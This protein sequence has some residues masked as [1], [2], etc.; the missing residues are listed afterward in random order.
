MHGIKIT[1]ENNERAGGT[2]R[3]LPSP[4]SCRR[5]G[6][7]VVVDSRAGGAAVPGRGLLLVPG[8]L[9][10]MMLKLKRSES[11]DLL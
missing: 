2:R 4:Q 8:L 9:A 1:A 10:K 6:V 3:G 11:G 5:Q 7:G